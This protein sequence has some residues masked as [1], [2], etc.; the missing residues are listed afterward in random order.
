MGAANSNQEVLLNQILGTLRHPPASGGVATEATLQAILA[1]ETLIEID[2]ETINLSVD[3]LE[4]LQTT[5]NASLSVLDDWDESD[6]AKVNLIVGQAGIAA[7]TGVDG[8][9]VPRV[10]LATNVALPAGTNLLGIVQTKETPDAAS[11]YA[12]DADDSAAYE[13]SSVSKA[14]PGVLYGCFGYNSKATAQFIQ[15]HNTTSLPADAQVPI[16]TFTVPALSNFSLDF[17]K[18]GKYFSTGITWCNS[19]TGPT[20]TI[21]SADVWMNVQY[22]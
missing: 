4:A 22:K 17:G 15:V 13:A 3:G 8:V 5:A 6:R 18:F 14:S 9:T 2:T 11:T 10:S 7:G 1:K 19:S 20:K 12:P 21:G 16:I